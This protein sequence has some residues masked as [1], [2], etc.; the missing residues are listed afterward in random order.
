MI[1]QKKKDSEIQQ[2]YREYINHK[3]F[4]EMALLIENSKIKPAEYIVRMGYKSY[5]EKGKGNRVKFFALMK[6]KEITGIKP[7]I[8]VMKKTCELA[9]SMDSPEVFEALMKR[10]DIDK[11]VF[12]EMNAEFQKIYE[13]YVREGRFVDISR[14]MELTNT[15]ASEE[16]IQKGYEY[17][18]SEGKFI[19]FAG[20]KKRTGVSPNEE[21]IHNSY[22]EFYAHYMK[23]KAISKEKAELWFD[24]IK[25][26]KRISK[27]NPK[28]FKIED[29]EGKG[30]SSEKEEKDK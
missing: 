7:D 21:M 1:N 3:R 23:S 24:R 6:L 4:S 10:M 30:K 14:L 13:Q 22:Q 12:Q 20:L 15:Q 2:I 17:Y 5:L 25:K 9:L 11:S 18:L 19:S 8:D 16:I 26:L 28:K 27:I 29:L